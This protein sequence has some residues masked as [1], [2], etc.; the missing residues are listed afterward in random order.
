MD[1]GQTPIV[2]P[3]AWLVAGL[4]V[5]AHLLL[6]KAEWRQL[7]RAPGMPA[8]L[9][10]SLFAQA[11]PLAVPTVTPT[12]VA[13]LSPSPALNQPRPVIRDW[14][15][16]PTP[17]EP[18]VGLSGDG[19]RPSPRGPAVEPAS[20]GRPT[21]ESAAAPGPAMQARRP[22]ASAP[23]AAPLAPANDGLPAA[24]LTSPSSPSRSAE[25]SGPAPVGASSKLEPTQQARIE[26]PLVAAEY[27][28]ITKDAYPELSQRLGEQGRVV[29]RI[30][31]AADGSAQRA[32]ISR[33]SGFERL[34]KSA[35]TWVLRW[36]YQPGRRGD[37]PEAMW[38]T[39][40]FTFALEERRTD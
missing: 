8:V 5:G 13:N 27:L 36:R 1:S 7:V 28:S 20:A 38:T 21:A 39:A 14:K 22:E 30:L 34:D 17:Q 2:G 15:A 23:T 24:G 9:N 4:V 26:L 25:V 6:V 40:P 19:H 33:S 31:I 16:D 35:L 32:E 37:V 18:P 11:E 10:V 3:R 29:V 12:P